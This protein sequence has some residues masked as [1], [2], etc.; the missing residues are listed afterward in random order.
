MSDAYFMEV[1]QQGLYL[2]LLLSL[3]PLAA[4]LLAGVV[5]GLL[6]A[7]T[8]VWDP[9]I[10]LLPRVAAVLLALVLAGPWTGEQLVRFSQLL[11]QG[12]PRL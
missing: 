11:W 9:A 6:Q 7:G 3:P 12:I 2:V 1:L 4:G 8:R 10:A 5:T